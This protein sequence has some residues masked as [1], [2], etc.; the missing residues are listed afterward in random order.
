MAAEVGSTDMGKIFT[1]SPAIKAVCR[2]ALDDLITELAKN[3]RIFYP[4]K[5]ID[6][7]NCVQ[8]PNGD[9]GASY[10]RHGGPMKFMTGAACPMCNS[11]HQRAEYVSEDFQWLCALRPKDF[12]I[13]I[14]N[15]DFKV[16]F[17]YVQTKMF[18]QDVPKALASEYMVFQTAISG[19]SGESRY[20]LHSKPVDVSNIIQN[21][22]FVATWEMI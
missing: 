4:P 16:P 10:W 6:C 1:L 2:D 20:K 3:C 7:V 14:P 11:Q 5:F 18:S 22:Y 21:R 12:F 15:L 19:L 17:G 13:P 9:Q 8:D